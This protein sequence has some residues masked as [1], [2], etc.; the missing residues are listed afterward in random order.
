LPQ[1]LQLLPKGAGM[2][3]AIRRTL[4]VGPEAG[5][6]LEDFGVTRDAKHDLTRDD[7]LNGNVDLIAKAAAL[8]KKGTAREFE[9]VA[10]RAGDDVQIGV[11]ARNVDSIDVFVGGRPR[12]SKTVGAGGVKFGIPAKRN[13][14]IELRGYS[15]DVLVCCRRLVL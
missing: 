2:R 6:E 9:V 14:E 8:L 13:A 1:P 10:K 3:V 7:L 11:K 4:R 5:T 12:L 15:G